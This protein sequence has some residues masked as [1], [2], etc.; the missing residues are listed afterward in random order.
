MRIANRFPRTSATSALLILAAHFSA[1]SAFAAIHELKLTGSASAPNDPTCIQQ[2]TDIASKFSE[3]AGVSIVEIVCQADYVTEK[4]AVIRYAAPNPV[5]VYNS[6]ADQFDHHNTGYETAE[7]CSAGLAAEIDVYRHHTGIS[8]FAGYCYNS[9]TPGSG[10]VANYKTAIYGIN[11]K[12]GL[13][14]SRKFSAG[15]SI[16]MPPMDIPSVK[17]MTTDIARRAGIDIV[18]VNIGHGISNLEIS[19]S[20][21][22][23]QYVNILSEPLGHFAPGTSC[24]ENAAALNQSW[25]TSGLIEAGFFCMD[26]SRDARRLGMVWWS[27][28]PFSGEDFVVNHLDTKYPDANACNTGKVKLVDGLTRAGEL[29]AA[30]ICSHSHNEIPTSRNPL[31]Y[32]VTVITK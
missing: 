25:N 15:T 13:P 27:H 24:E 1:T 17:I 16:G 14:A 26:A 4:L 29:V 30:A 12:P 22:G 10:W 28:H 8:P 21:Y 32:Q 9:M 20:F 18:S 11:P 6:S 5:N 31:P 2:A 7:D 23:S 3:S 19:A